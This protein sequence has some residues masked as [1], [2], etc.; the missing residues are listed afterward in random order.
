MPPINPEGTGGSEATE[1]IV[2]STMESEFASY[3]G[4]G[5][6]GGS[7]TTDG[8]SEI[9]SATTPGGTQIDESAHPSMKGWFSRLRQ[10]QPLALPAGRSI[11][12][13]G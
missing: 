2:S 11:G 7:V 4:S 13:R 6:I 5:I 1:V 9:V 10:Q 12:A 8:S 3:V